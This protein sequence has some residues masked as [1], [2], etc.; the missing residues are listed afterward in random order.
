[1][2]IFLS[3]SVQSM[4]K[5]ASFG[6]HKTCIKTGGKCSLTFFGNGLKIHTCC[7]ACTSE[8]MNLTQEVVVM[9]EDRVICEVTSVTPPPVRYHGHQ[10][11]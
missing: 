1:M 3:G 10:R 11:A 4:I 2:Y 7:D 6:M 8:L 9:I 5:L